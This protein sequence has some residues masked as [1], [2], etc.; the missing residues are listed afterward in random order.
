MT[1]RL[2]DY[3]EEGKSLD[4]DEREIAALALQQIDESEQS[5]VDDAWDRTI[6]E[7]I[8]EILNGD[9]ELVSGEESLAM[10]RA[11]LAAQREE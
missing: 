8:D 4:A 6:D 2:R 9:V 1:R 11:L 5:E 7:R 3:I 10:G